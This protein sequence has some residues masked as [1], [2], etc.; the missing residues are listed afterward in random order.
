MVATITPIL[1]FQSIHTWISSSTCHDTEPKG[2]SIGLEWLDSL[3]DIVALGQVNKIRCNDQ[4]NETHV[5]RRDQFDSM[6]I[7]NVQ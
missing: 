1:F 6:Q 4:N 2:V 3:E 7:G 5:H